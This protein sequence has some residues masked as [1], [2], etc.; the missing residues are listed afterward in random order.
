M[1]YTV[2]GLAI[3]WSMALIWVFFTPRLNLGIVEQ[4]KINDLEMTVYLDNKPLPACS[5]DIETR[6]CRYSCAP[7]GVCVFV[8]NELIKKYK[9]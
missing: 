8:P 7:D 5:E 3:L 1:I 2:C 4:R 6:V 9:F